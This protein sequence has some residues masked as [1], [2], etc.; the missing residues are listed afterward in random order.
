MSGKR[1]IRI[2]DVC[3]GAD[4]PVAIQSMTNTDTKDTEATVRQIL[5][6]EKAGCEIIRV[7]AY[8]IDAAR[9]IRNIRDRI[10]IPLV[11][12]VHFDYRI[13]VAAMESGADKVR[14]NPGNIGSNDRIRIVADAAKAHH[15]PIRVGAN[16]GSLAREYQGSDRSRAL[17]ESAMENV[18]ALE[19]FG[20]EDIVVA[21]KSSDVSE[22]VR[23]YR[24]M[25][26]EVDYPLHVGITEAG[27]YEKSIVK[28]SIGIGSLLLDGIGDTIRVS[29]TGDPVLEIEA[30]KDILQFSGRR[31]FGP[32]IVACPTCGRT[33]IDLE[34]LYRK[35][36]LLVK[37]VKKDIR[38][39]VMGCIVNGPGEARNADLGIAGGQGEGVIFIKGEPVRKVD[40]E[41]LLEEFG[42]VLREYI[43]EDR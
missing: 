25:D 14:I 3:I 34:D 41:H 32:D 35:V 38:I 1:L 10:H 27:G 2:G 19:S 9:N 6:L 43:G 39:A 33:R 4:R 28:S 7:A 24:M 22:T 5:S 30:A 13:A 12:D 20:F 42:K 40:E 37:D 23:A 31:T 11:A 21:L 26:R 17:F 16:T 18:R 15:I 29:I 8:D 36:S